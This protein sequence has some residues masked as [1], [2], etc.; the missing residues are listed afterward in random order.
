MHEKERHQCIFDGILGLCFYVFTSYRGER[1]FC[2]VY[3]SLIGLYL[4]SS[5][6]GRLPGC[7][8]WHEQCAMFIRFF[9][10]HSHYLFI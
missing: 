1:T 3:I 2:I 10:K 8:H 5:E 7:S 6:I 4:L 9:L